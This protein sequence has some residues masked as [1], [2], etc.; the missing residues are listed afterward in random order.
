MVVVGALA[1]VPQ[2]DVGLVAV[3]DMPMAF[4]FALLPVAALVLGLADLQ[5]I[6]AFVV[7][8][9]PLVERLVKLVD[10][11]AQQVTVYTTAHFALAFVVAPA[12]HLPVVHV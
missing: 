1:V 5:L 12:V 11:N 4:G 8:L 7:V 3:V 6:V 10:H 2:L 9:L